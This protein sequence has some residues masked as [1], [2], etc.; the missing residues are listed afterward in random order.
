VYDWHDLGDFDLFRDGDLLYRRVLAVHVVN[1]QVVA[2]HC[3]TRQWKE[4]LSCD[5]SVMTSATGAARSLPNYVLSI[6]I[7]RCRSLG[8][9]VRYCPHVQWDDPHYNLA[10]CLLVLPPNVTSKPEIEDLRTRFLRAAKLD[11]LT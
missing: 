6:T 8:L 10:H 4:G 7:G 2:A 5:W 11:W 9:D 1:G 3:P